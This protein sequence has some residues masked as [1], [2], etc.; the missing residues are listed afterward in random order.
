VTTLLI[1]GNQKQRVKLQK[2]ARKHTKASA[3]ALNRPDFEKGRR[4]S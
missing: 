3:N 4:A 1:A 2:A